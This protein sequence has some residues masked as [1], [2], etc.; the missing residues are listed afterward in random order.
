MRPARSVLLVAALLLLGLVLTPATAQS[1]SLIP[2][3][4]PQQ[5]QR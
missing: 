2:T 5:P 3:G 1:L 4:P